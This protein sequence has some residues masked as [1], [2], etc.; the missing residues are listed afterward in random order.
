LRRASAILIIALLAA[1]QRAAAGWDAFGEAALLGGRSDNPEL[2]DPALAGEPETIGS[3]DLKFGA[4]LRERRTR[5]HVLYAPEG[6]YYSGSGTFRTF[7]RLEAV[8]ARTLSPRNG[9][10]IADGFAY[11]PE[12][13]GGFGATAATPLVQGGR[14]S[15]NELRATWTAKPGP[16][17][18]LDVSY[19]D[20]WVAFSDPGLLDSIHRG[21]A[22]D[23][24]V[25]TGTRLALLAGSSLRYGR[26]DEERAEAAV[27]AV[28]TVDE[29]PGSRLANGYGGLRY[30][31]PRGSA[32]LVAGVDSVK[33]S[34][35]DPEDETALMVRSSL[36]WKAWRFSGRLGYRRGLDDG[37]GHFV[38]SLASSGEAS[39][40]LRIGRSMTL[41]LSASRT[42]REELAPEG[43]E[44]DS[45]ETFRRRGV[46]RYQLAPGWSLLAA[47]TYDAQESLGVEAAP[48]VRSTRYEVGFSCS[49]G[50][51]L[52]GEEPGDWKEPQ[53][54]SGKTATED[55]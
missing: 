10:R 27:P 39:A 35:A 23:L 48:T 41:D 24:T 47:V 46:A 49:F 22:L 44:A 30:G 1:P 25:R 51:P 53:D 36:G 5:F 29:D 52:A 54:D 38:H 19:D 50:D 18:Q 28:E 7:H 42:R 33:L 12:A 43:V 34:S 15:S 55:E 3:L 37:G 14:V 6:D 4:L 21:G 9:L 16:R 13:S 17:I 26:F 2:V 11:T 31:G 40:L 32:E 45:L 20:R 8:W